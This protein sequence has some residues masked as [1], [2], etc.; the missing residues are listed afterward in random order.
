MYESGSTRGVVE[1]GADAPENEVRAEVEI[2]M[3]VTVSEEV[4]AVDIVAIVA[5]GRTCPV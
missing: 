4:M 1:A 3:E 5:V 2:G